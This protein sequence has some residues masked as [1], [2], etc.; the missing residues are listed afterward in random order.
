M[1][2]TRNRI[3]AEDNVQSILLTIE[4]SQDVTTTTS[5]III[6]IMFITMPCAHVSTSYFCALQTLSI[7]CM[8]TRMHLHSILK[9]K[10][11][12]ICVP[13]ALIYL[14]RYLTLSA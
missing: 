2:R 8:S 3:D 12:L 10:K 14:S 11:R 7:S 4:H 6:K 1:Q 9:Y 5:L 13:V